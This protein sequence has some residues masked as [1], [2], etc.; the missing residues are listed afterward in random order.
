MKT[1]PS[2]T[3]NDTYGFGKF[4]PC[5]LCGELLRDDH[6]WVFEDGTV[7]CRDTFRCTK[8]QARNRIEKAKAEG[9]W[10]PRWRKNDK[11]K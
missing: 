10:M 2:G 7:E 5:R 8:H 3:V 9:T 4:V 6:G 1:L 11:E